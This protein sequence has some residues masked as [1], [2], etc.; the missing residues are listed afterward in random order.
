MNVEYIILNHLTASKYVLK[1][2]RPYKFCETLLVPSVAL[3]QPA[4]LKVLGFLKAHFHKMASHKQQAIYMPN[5]LA[6]IF[7]VLKSESNGDG[8]LNSE[9][10]PSAVNVIKA[11]ES[12][13]VSAI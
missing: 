12:R 8:F 5:K 7:T 2:V 9:T 11:F 13:L 4:L 3:Y 1:F 10:D 6:Q